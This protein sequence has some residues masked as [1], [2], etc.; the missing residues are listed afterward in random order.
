VSGCLRECAEAQGKDVGL[1]ATQKG[2]NLYVCGNGGA[3]PVHATLLGTDLSEEE[4]I[5]YIDR[6][7]MYYISTAKHL[8]RTAPW[9]EEL[10]GGIEFLKKVV[11]DDSLGIC[12]ELEALLEHAHST[13]KCEWKEVAYETRLHKKFQQFVNTTETHDSEQIEYVPMRRQAH[14]NA[15]SPPDITGPASFRRE[16]APAEGTAAADGW[17]W[18]FAGNIEDFP[19]CGG[20]TMKHGSQ[21]VAIFRVSGVS[22]TS[23]P[24]RWFA[25][26][27]ICPHKQARTISRGLVGETLDGKVTLADPVYKTTYN[28]E[29]GEGL[30]NPLLNLSTFEVRADDASGQVLVWLPGC[31]VMA[32]AFH[33]QIKAA[34]SGFE[35]PTKGRDIENKV[36]DIEDMIPMRAMALGA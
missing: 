18:T 30:A 19:K 11:I 4:C 24:T 21:E 27:N 29:T 8:Q 3:K 25:T 12:A 23:R 13:Y 15:Y 32:A 20:L 28:L 2:Y 33:T 6:T 1:I 5:K 22:D 34:V 10:P 36:I 31:D 35:R 14:P 17:A 7:L 16:S 9:L 26:Q